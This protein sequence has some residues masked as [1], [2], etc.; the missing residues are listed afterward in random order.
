M[1]N[2]I[3]LS[4]SDIHNLV[5]NIPVS[6]WINGATHTICTEEYYDKVI[7]GKEI[8]KEQWKEFVKL[9]MEEKE[10][11]MA[12]ATSRNFKRWKAINAVGK[13]EN[14]SY[15]SPKS[16]KGL[17]DALKYFREHKPYGTGGN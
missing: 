13:H 7:F 11:N 16:Q 5:N 8:D 12:E 3:V 15:V 6:I 9:K 4:N 17:S 10:N 14:M 1:N 2:Y